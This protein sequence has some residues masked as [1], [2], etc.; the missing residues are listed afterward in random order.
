MQKPT[1][2]VGKVD[3]RIKN[4]ALPA[5]S[6]FGSMRPA[7]C[8]I[9][10]RDGVSTDGERTHVGKDAGETNKGEDDKNENGGTKASP[11]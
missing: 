3:S 9:G 11:E 4:D 6:T 1:T 10:I 8:M 5:P 2:Q 7:H